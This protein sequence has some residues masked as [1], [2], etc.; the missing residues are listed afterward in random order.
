MGQAHA[1]AWCDGTCYTA[2][3]ALNPSRQCGKQKC[4]GCP[5][6]NE[7]TCA[8]AVCPEDLCL[9]GSSRRPIGDDCCACPEP[10]IADGGQWPQPEPIIFDGSRPTN[11]IVGE[12]EPC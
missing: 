12:G 7:E 5:E 6:C 4:K 11:Q 3:G 8:D 10:L 1:E 2:K 9:D